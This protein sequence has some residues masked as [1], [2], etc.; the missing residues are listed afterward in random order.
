MRAVPIPDPQAIPETADACAEYLSEADAAWDAGDVTLAHHLYHALFESEQRN[1]EQSARST[2]RL[3]LIALNAGDHEQARV[4]AVQSSEPA[5]K[6]VLRSI[7]NAAG[8]VTADPSRPPASDHEAE[9]WWA[10]GTKARTAGDYATAMSWFGLII[11]ST[12]LTPEVHAHAE[13]VM[14]LCAHGSGDDATARAWLDQAFPNLRGTEVIEA[15]Q[16]L[17]EQIGVHSRDDDTSPA[18]HQLEAGIEAYRLGDA[19][20]ARSAL[21]AAL[22]LDGSTDEIKGRA[23]FY[24]GA[25]DY[26]QNKY[27]DARDHLERAVALAP[28]PEKTW[29]HDMLQSRWEEN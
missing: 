23:G 3:A 18:A 5:A 19:A 26:Q 29:A 14:A 7:D 6:D 4:Y 28:D 1:H 13:M 15:A 16:K 21:E 2:Y 12:A 8:P 10:E 17:Y 11:Q 25:M 24:L 9:I 20:A 22:H 27:A